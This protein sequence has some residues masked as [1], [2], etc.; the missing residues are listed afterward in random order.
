[1]GRLRDTKVLITGGANGA[2]AASVR[3]FCREGAQ[4]VFVNRDRAAGQSLAREAE[5]RG[6]PARCVEADVAEPDE[7]A[8]VAEALDHL[9]RIDVL[10]NHAG[11]IIVKPFL[12]F[13]LAEWDEL[14]DNNAKS[15]FLMCRLVLPG[16]L[17]RG[18]GLSSPRR[19]GCERQAI[20]SRSTA[21]RH[22]PGMPWRARSP[23]NIATRASA[24]TPY[25]R[26]SCAP[27]TA[28]TRSNRCAPTVSSPVRTT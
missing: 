1:M 13:T 5:A 3:R 28:R 12:E 8:A 16:M 6:M 14:M 18:R 26:A 21:P 19:P 9:G 11:I 15:A 10:F 27:R 23:S 7:A 17:E 4:L 25:A 2:G 24:R 20:S 22:R